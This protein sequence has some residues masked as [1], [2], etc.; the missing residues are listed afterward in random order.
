[1]PTYEPSPEFLKAY[2]ALSPE[3][4]KK[5]RRAVEHFIEDLNSGRRFRIGLRVKGIQGGP[6]G[7]FEM[8]WAPNGRAI[9]SYGDEI[10]EGEPHIIWHAVGTHAILP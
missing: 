1:V 10:L 6:D 2:S 4:K 5:F 7:M 3:Q 9:F 8:T